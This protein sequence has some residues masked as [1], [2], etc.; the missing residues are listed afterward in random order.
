MTLPSFS[1][2]TGFA[3][4][5]QKIGFA[6]AGTA[7]QLVTGIFYLATGNILG[8]LTA[9]ASA[10]PMV[11]KEV[12]KS[13]SELES[14]RFRSFESL[15]DRLSFAV[16]DWRCALPISTVLG[17]LG[18]FALVSS[19]VLVPVWLGVTA[20]WAVLYALATMHI[21]KQQRRFRRTS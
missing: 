1:L 4:T 9:L 19:S 21:A 5:M 11:V 13:P 16:V 8:G 10:I 15:T 18:Y 6:L 12:W 20:L 17:F 2:P 14:T 7:P 3:N